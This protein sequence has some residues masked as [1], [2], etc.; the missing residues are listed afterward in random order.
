[1]HELNDLQTSFSEGIL[2][3]CCPRATPKTNCRLQADRVVADKSGNSLTLRM[4]KPADPSTDCIN[5]SYQ[6]AH[7]A[8]IRTQGTE[9]ALFSN[10]GAKFI[11]GESLKKL[12]S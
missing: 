3:R 5:V 9:A 4:Y 6:A 1:M 11:F 12:S 2:E 10:L 7:I 8:R